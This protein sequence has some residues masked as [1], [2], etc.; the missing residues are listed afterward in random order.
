MNPSA[1]LLLALKGTCALNCLAALHLAGPLPVTQRTV[2]DLT[3]FDDAAVSKGLATLRVLGLV[4]C[5]GDT[6][7]TGWQLSPA[8]RNLP[9]PL[10]PLLVSPDNVDSGALKEEE[11]KE[12]E[13]V[14]VDV[15]ESLAIPGASNP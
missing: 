11:E 9:L 7:R 14:I 4:T 2:M 8:A 5:T 12:K 6:K 10:D 15:L 3:G 1:L 13:R